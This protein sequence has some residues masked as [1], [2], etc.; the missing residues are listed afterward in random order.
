LYT[1]DLENNTEDRKIL[2][3]IDEVTEV[4]EEKADPNKNQAKQRR[5]SSR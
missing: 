1:K 5:S 4:K 2:L 3:K